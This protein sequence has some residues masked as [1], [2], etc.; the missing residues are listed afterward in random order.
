MVCGGYSG[1]ITVA[2]SSG[3]A[4]FGSDGV[5]VAA[6]AKTTFMEGERRDGDKFGNIKEKQISTVYLKI[7]ISNGESLVFE[8]I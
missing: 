5:V 3:G 7:Y 1:G 2:G 8:P 6:I 4:V